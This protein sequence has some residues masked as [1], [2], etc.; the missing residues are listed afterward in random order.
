MLLCCH[1][2]LHL[3]PVLGYLWVMGVRACAIALFFLA[4]LVRIY[5]I[6]SMLHD[7]KVLLFPDDP[8]YHMLRVERIHQGI[9]YQ[10]QK[11]PLIAHPFGAVA[12]WPTFFDLF[13][14]LLSFP[15]SF[16]RNAVVFACSLIVPV[17][18]SL[19]CV[20]LFLFASRYM[21]YHHALFSGFAL[22]ILPTHSD[23]TIF[24]RVDHHVLEP[25]AV[26]ALV[27]LGLEALKKPENTRLFALAGLSGGFS[28]ALFPSALA[29]S[30]PAILVFSIIFLFLCPQRLFVFAI[31]CLLGLCLALLFSPHPLEFVFY[32]PSL[33]HILVFFG[34]FAL[35]CTLSYFRLK[36]KGHA[37]GF[38]MVLF[39]SLCVFMLFG[40]KPVMEGLKYLGGQGFASLSSEATPT[41]AD[42]K[43]LYSILGFS[44]VLAPFGAILLFQKKE[45]RILAVISFFYLALA[46]FQ[47]RF[48]VAFSPFYCILLSYLFF[49]G[50]TKV[51]KVLI[52]AFVVL[53]FA[54]SIYHLVHIEPLSAQD[55]A[56]YE[57]TTTLRDR[58]GAILTPWFYGHVFQYET[59][60]PTLCDN[61][62]G[63]P[64]SDE[65]LFRCLSLLYDEDENRVFDRLERYGVKNIVI[66]PPHPEQVQREV[67]LLGLDEK[68]Y[69]HNR[70]LTTEFLKTFWG[71]LGM[72]GMR[73]KEGNKMHS[74]WILERK[75]HYPDDENPEAEVFVF[76]RNPD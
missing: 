25:I 24:A 65:A 74:G 3:V 29:V 71:K 16:D 1:V 8:P 27:F 22:S 6:H 50:R 54:P 12:I 44:W 14:A 38:F 39:L 19:T 51:V 2:S 52:K 5:P 62:F 57:A 26:L 40:F 10:I 32:S 36:K 11:D 18:G 72:F 59:K 15:F 56:I 47:R 20:L 66:V 28:F 76:T 41:L 42:P 69:V 21:P 37:Y 58:D 61:F 55:K 17:L 70:A 46:L 4:F 34:F 53:S 7:S 30:F 48:L 75:I 33:L 67:R 35:F 45:T 73:A 64:E 13:L 68:G 43:R 60:R 9:L 23:Y 31:S 49:F 63:V